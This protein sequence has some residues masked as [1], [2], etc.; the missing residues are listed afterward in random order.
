MVKYFIQLTPSP[1]DICSQSPLEL[2]A[3]ANIL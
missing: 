2:V 3:N 1:Y